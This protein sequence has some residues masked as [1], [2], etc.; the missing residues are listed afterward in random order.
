MMRHNPKWATFNS[1]Y[2]N[3]KVQFDIQNAVLDEPSEDGLIRLL[4]HISSTRDSRAARDM[5]PKEVWSSLPPDPEI[6]ELRRRRAELKGA[7]YGIKNNVNKDMIQKLTAKIWSQQAERDK[8]IRIEY[9]K[10]YFHNRPTW[11]IE[12]Q[13]VSGEEED[14]VTPVIE[15]QIPERAELADDL[16]NQPDDL[17]EEGLKQLRIRAVDGMVAL[18]RKRETAK[19]KNPRQRAPANIRVKEESPRPDSFPLL[20]DRKQCPICIGDETLSH[21][22]RTFIYCR[23]T[24]MYDHFDKKHAQQLGVTQMSCNH[25]R[26]REEALE[27]KHLNHFKSHV[28]KVHGVRLRA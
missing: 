10:F 12:R 23:P 15:L 4:T 24:V 27:F 9:R 25:P 17:L 11:D 18:C 28:Q 3:E 5:V 2:I 26:C 22:E 20:M 16:V 21:E 14:Y 19:R 13:A 6:E 1:A 7:S 8:M